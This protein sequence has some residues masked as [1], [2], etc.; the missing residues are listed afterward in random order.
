MPRY[1]PLPIPDGFGIIEFGQKARFQ[2]VRP[3]PDAPQRFL[4]LAAA[5][6][7]RYQAMVDIYR[8][9]SRQTPDDQQ[10]S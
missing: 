5:R 1:A 10:L 2:A 8:Y 6:T 9:Q 7:T 3:D 4:A